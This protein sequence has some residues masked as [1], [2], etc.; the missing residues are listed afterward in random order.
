[1]RFCRLFDLIENKSSTVADMCSLGWGVGGAAWLWRRQLWAWEEE[2]LGEC[3][4][5]LHSLLLQVQSPDLW[6][7]QPDANSGYSV[8][9]AYQILTSHQPDPLS[10]AK[11]LLWHRRVPI[12]VSILAWRLPRD[13]FPTKAN[14]AARGIITTEAQLCVSGCRGVESAQHL[15]LSCTFFGSLWDLLRTWI[16]FS[17]VD[18]QDLLNHFH[19]FTHSSGGL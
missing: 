9:G 8:R 6:Q 11:D 13:R 1:V 17:T 18:P 7:W 12:K 5:L 14:L 16:D 15:F 3:Q 2:L 10:A 4:N 19:Q